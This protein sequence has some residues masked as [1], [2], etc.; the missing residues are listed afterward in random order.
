MSH[1][2]KEKGGKTY[3]FPDLILSPYRLLGNRIV[4]VLPQFEDLKES[5]I[6]S[7]LKIAFPAYVA[8]MFFFSSLAVA[9]TFAIS[10]TI[11]LLLYASLL[12]SLLLSGVFA[13]FA[14]IIILFV[15]YSYP[16]TNESTRK[17]HLKEELPY[18]A[19][20]MAVLSQAGLTPE[21]IFRSL[22]STEV[23]SFKSIAAEEATDVVRDVYLMGFDIVSAMGRCSKRDLHPSFSE[24]IDGMIG[25]TRSGGSLTK[26]FLTSAREFMIATRIA[27]RQLAET[28][29]TV[30]EAYVSLMVVFPLI[31][32][33]MLSVMG[34]VGGSLGGFS[35]T[36]I[37]YLI[38]YL[39]LPIFALIMMVMLDSIMPPR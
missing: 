14:G 33:V 16:S 9:V 34:M 24:F 19:S 30:A 36:S 39:L 12:W 22:A 3:G 31:A 1:V 35:I 32:V 7:R 18:M 37:M 8:F 17:R 26:Y 4:K 27:A 11:S 5:L 2:S 29:G 20:H 10:L 28:L 23:K 13:L 15:L 38:A 25:V 21:R 6:K